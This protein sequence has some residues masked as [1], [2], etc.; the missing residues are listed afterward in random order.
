MNYIVDHIPKDTPNNRR[1]AIKMEPEYITIHNTGNPKST[2]ANERD[3]LSNK[4]N[5]RTA[6]YHFVV[7]ENDVIECLPLDEVSWNAGDAYGNG[8]MKS[9]SIEICESGNFDKAMDNAENLVVKLMKE[10]K[11]GTDKVK[12]HFDWSGKICPRKLYNDGT[13]VGWNLFLK[14]VKEKLTKKEVAPWKLEGLQYLYTNEL[15]EDYDLWKEKIDEPIPFWA[16][17]LILKRIH[18]SK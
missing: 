1:P 10:R 5:K 3:W 11:W 17:A 7:D 8:N 4:N 14:N 15:L 12:R 13:W 16:A 9:I 6:S 2:A 18:E